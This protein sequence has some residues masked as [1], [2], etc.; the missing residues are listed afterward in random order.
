VIDQ[1]PILLALRAGAPYLQSLD[2]APSAPPAFLLDARRLAPGREVSPGVFDNR[3][4]VFAQDC[5][6]VETLKARGVARV[7]L[8]QRGR[9]VPRYDLADVL[10]GWQHGGLAVLS[11]DLDDPAPPAPFRV[12][13][14]PWHR[15]A[16]HRILE[17]L[18]L[19]RSPPGGFG[20]IVPEPSHG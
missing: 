9:W 7:V 10:R 6:S 8:V 16:W 3:W 13:P 20:H 1:L 18:G 17:A 14:L 12:T 2:L 19:R 4:Q 5:P 15:A 11:K